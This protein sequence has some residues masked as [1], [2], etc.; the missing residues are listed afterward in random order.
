MTVTVDGLRRVRLPRVQLPGSA[1][2]GRL[3]SAWSTA[4]RVRPGGYVLL[5]ATVAVLNIVG[6][7]MI[8]SA[9]SVQS[10]DSKG[11]AWWFFERQLLWTGLGVAGFAIAP[12]R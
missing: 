6:T 11:T 5:L 4:G 1:R 7:V 12:A 8:L 10:L 2:L 3:A 9:S